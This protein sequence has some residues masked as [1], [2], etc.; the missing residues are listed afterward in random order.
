VTLRLGAPRLAQGR[1]VAHPLERH[2]DV[3]VRNVRPGDE[4]GLRTLLRRATVFELHEIRVAEELIDEAVRGSRDYVVY[5]AE[6]GTAPPDTNIVGY[7][8]H[9]HNP[10]TDAM[11]DLY[12]IAVD[13]AAQGRGVGRAL[14]AHTERSVRDLRGR[15][16]A[17]ET[18]SRSEYLPAR[19]LYE[20]CGYRKVAEIPDFYK[21]GDNRIVYVKFVI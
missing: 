6:A 7:A 18:S 15:G 17:I 2:I 21:P 9:G 12:W 8:C 19:R 5:V 13:P 3:H 14:I 11:H 20:S 10:V 16:I 1:H 4:D